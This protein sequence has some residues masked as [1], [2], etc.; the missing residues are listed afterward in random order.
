MH[1]VEIGFL[2]PA[3]DVVHLAQPALGQHRADRAA[4]ILDVQPVA[5]L[6]AVAVHRQRLA[7]ERVDDHQRDQ[8]LGKMIGAVVVGAVGGQHR[9]PVGVVVGAHQMVAGGL[10]GG[11]R[12]V[13]FVAMGFAE[14]R[15][16]L[17]KRAVHFVGGDMQK[18]ES[19]FFR[20]RQTRPVA[21]HRFEQIEGADDVGLDEIAGTV[22]GAIH[23]ALRREVDYRARAVLCEQPAHQLRIADVALHEDVA[24]VVLQRCEVFQIARVGQLV[25][26][27]DWFAALREPVQNKVGADEACTASH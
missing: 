21:A 8:L 16:V 5:D 22:D 20:I 4:M 14:R 11:V 19:G 2:V 13:R 7:R 3:A 17:R 6:L 26:I 10:A 15:I 23:M 12:A 9:Q 1:D 27:D 18:A 24:R 25:E